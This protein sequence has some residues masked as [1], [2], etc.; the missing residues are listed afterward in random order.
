MAAR[1]H[2]SNRTPGRSP[3]DRIRTVVAVALQL[4]RALVAS[5]I[6]VVLVAGLP[7]ALVH[8]VGWPLPDHVPTW[9][10][11]Q[12]TALSPMSSRFLLNVLAVI[13]WVLWIVFALD[14]ARY[15]VDAAHGTSWSHP[16]GSRKG[17]V[18]A[19]VGTIVLTLLGNRAA[20]A[21]PVLPVTLT[22]EPAPTAIVAPLV[23]GPSGS[24]TVRP[25][26]ATSPT[27]TIVIDPTAPAP[28]GL[29]LATEEV[30]T[31]Q[32]GVHDSLW[33]IAER[34]F[35]PGGGRRWPELFQLNRGVP[36]HDGQTLTVPTLVRPGWMITAYIPQPLPESPPDTPPSP[37]PHAPPPAPT[38]QAPAEAPSTA[39]HDADH[40]DPGLNP[41]TGAFVSVTL[42]AAITA[43]M[44]SARLWR[45]RS[46]R[47]GSGDR[48]DLQRPTAPVIRALRDAHDH[49]QI[50]GPAAHDVE[51]V[52]LTPGHSLGDAKATATDEVRGERGHL[53][54]KIGVRN[55]HELA[56]SLASAHGLGLAGPGAASAARALL[57]HLLTERP[58]VSVGVLI[59]ADDLHGV[60]D[61]P[62]IEKL[63]SA[64]QVVATLDD[65]VTEME[66]ALLT[67][68]RGLTEEDEHPSTL[69]PLVLLASPSQRVEGRLQ[70]VL[71][72]GSTL[73]LAGILLGQWRP[74]STV[75]V[76]VDGTIGGT[77]PGPGEALAGVRLF[78]L[79]T[80]DASALLAALRD[81]ECAAGPIDGEQAGVNGAP[82]TPSHDDEKGP[83]VYA[84]AVPR[85]RPADRILP[86][87]SSR[88]ATGSRA[89]G[90]HSRGH[91]SAAEP[92]MAPLQLKVLGRVRFSVTGEP[93]V[94]L[95]PALAPRQR[96]ILIFLACH[97]DGCRRDTLAAALWPNA[98][99]DRPYNSFHATM[100][101][102]R[103][104]LR[105][106]TD[107]VVGDV[108][109]TE[110]GRYSLDRSMVTVDLWDVQK[111]LHN[112]KSASSASARRE[113]LRHATEMYGGD[114]A[115][116]VSAEWIEAPREAIRRSILD[117]YSRLVRALGP[118]DLDQALDVLERA[119]ELDPFN[120]AIYRDIMRVQARLRRFD[121]IPRTM[122]IMSRSLQ[123]IGEHPGRATTAL[124]EELG[125]GRQPGRGRGAP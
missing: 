1:S 122:A 84:E 21:T 107:G 87:E 78:T 52:D 57:L 96:D 112:A 47:I 13:L 2:G 19:L 85:Q 49:D 68:T 3:L 61:D 48:A 117:G 97:V 108:V 92:I 35:G 71:D 24:V 105:G 50:D 116:D 63:P 36:Q 40:A 81:A 16:P 55:G 100:S 111:F 121:G 44:V 86:L 15:I 12:I 124:A 7:W 109:V 31:P 43:A 79:P 73:G 110:D 75:L 22:G 125:Q 115:E 104:A 90:E 65:A 28:P 46:Y 62:E 83:V 33:R 59:P 6:L 5:V 60:F 42:A 98:P 10:E 76:R 82:P 58:E 93:P 37:A 51:Y 11:V 95:L 26:A 23:P 77:S 32:D 106:A 27:T 38:A 18:T 119:R 114:L 29:V 54:S 66:A 67:R 89:G 39:D 69:P 9:S 101:Q 120:E 102:M 53:L 80:A 91:T 4:L 14:V 25:A 88:L 94:S 64:V 118:D 17:M 103:R 123:A 45:R 113:S 74:G 8:F 20:Q 72:T 70:A 99:G 41:T 30:R 34:I 56:L